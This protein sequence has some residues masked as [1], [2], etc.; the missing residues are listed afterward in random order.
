ML[1][2]KKP[3]SDFL[4]KNKIDLNPLQNSDPMLMS[5][6]LATLE[7][8]LMS[9]RP[10]YFLDLEESTRGLMLICKEDKGLMGLLENISDS[11]IQCGKNFLESVVEFKQ[12]EPLTIDQS[13]VLNTQVLQ[14]N[15][16]QIKSPS[17]DEQAIGL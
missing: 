5:V 2:V 3:I 4:E 15:E 16:P 1:E 12:K 11:A 7:S 17:R 9:T 10:T 8:K 6:V 13:E 14:K